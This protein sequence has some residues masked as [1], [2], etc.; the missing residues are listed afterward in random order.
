MWL[1]K[2]RKTEENNHQSVGENDQ[3]VI[4]FPV[5]RGGEKKAENPHTIEN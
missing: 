5:S 4:G 1:R 3:F 2:K